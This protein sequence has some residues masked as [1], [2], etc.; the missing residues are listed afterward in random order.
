MISF[1]NVLEVRPSFWGLRKPVCQGCHKRRQ[2]APVG[3]DSGQGLGA[4][5]LRYHRHG[6]QRSCHPAPCR[7]ST[8]KSKKALIQ[9]L[10]FCVILRVAKHDDREPRGTDGDGPWQGNDEEIGAVEKMNQSYVHN[11]VS[12]PNR[13]SASTGWK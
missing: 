13:T 12:R 8:G 4:L 2:R 10:L 11:Q 1:F 6:Q 3:T 7:W 9:L 5:Q